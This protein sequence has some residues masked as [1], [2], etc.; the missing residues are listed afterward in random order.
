MLRHHNQFYESIFKGSGWSHYVNTRLVLEW[1]D[2]YT[3]DKRHIV[4]AKSPLAPVVQIP[5]NINEK[6]ETFDTFF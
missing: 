6:Y 3:E 4:I 5:Y 1:E 2:K